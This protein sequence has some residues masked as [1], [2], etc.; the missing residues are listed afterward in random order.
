MDLQFIICA[1]AIVIVGIAMTIG[2]KSPY[3]KGNK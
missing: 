2:M 1:S 3:E